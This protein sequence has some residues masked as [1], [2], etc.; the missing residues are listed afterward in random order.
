MITGYRI[1]K[2]DGKVNKRE[3]E[4]IDVKE[5]FSIGEVKKKSANA[6]AVSW[7][8]ETDYKSMGKLA[9]EGTLNYFADNLADKYEEKTDKGKKKLAL[10]GD[11]LKEVSNFVLRRGIIESIILA[12]SMLLPAPIQLPSVRVGAKKK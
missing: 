2:I 5:S 3:K 10:K 7:T 8:F 11:A 1:D 6:L 12:K 9:L 4:N